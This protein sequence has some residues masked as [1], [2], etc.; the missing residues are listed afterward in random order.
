MK[1]TNLA[2]LSLALTVTLATGA[3]ATKRYPLATPLSSAEAEVMNCRELELELVRGEQ[4]RLQIANTAQ[5]DWRSVAGFLG[6]WGIGNAM[7][8]SEADKAVQRRIVS[9]KDAQAAKTCT[10]GQSS[11][12]QRLKQAVDKVFG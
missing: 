8:K 12:L 11:L 7:A 5:T 2:I 6:D 3:C 4:V 9:L 1:S 10:A